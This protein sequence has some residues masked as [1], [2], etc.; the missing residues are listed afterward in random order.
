VIRVYDDAGN[1]IETQ[2]HKGQFKV[3]NSVSPNSRA[4]TRVTQC[5]W[6]LADIGA[7]VE[8]GCHIAS[9][10]DTWMAL[11]NGVGGMRDYDR[12]ISFNPALDARLKALQLGLLIRGRR[13]RVQIDREIQTA[14]Y[15]L[16]NGPDL[17]VMHCGNR[18]TLCEGK[19]AR[20]RI[21]SSLHSNQSTTEDET[22]SDGSPGRT[23]PV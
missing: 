18:V 3:G 21:P 10:G 22:P 13:L 12:Q 1:V 14:T 8:H 5:L 4:T 19:P 7:N 16:A 23:S 2:E 20:L 11:I 6:D 17:E 9:M 15:L